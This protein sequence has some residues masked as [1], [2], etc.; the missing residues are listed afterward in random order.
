MC[1]LLCGPQS[2]Y[3]TL[4]GLGG[5]QAGWPVMFGVSLTTVAPRCRKAPARLLRCLLSF[6]ASRRIDREIG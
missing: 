4:P 1:W 5:W 3:F 6:L 2:L